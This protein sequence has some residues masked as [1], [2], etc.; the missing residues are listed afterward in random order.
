[1]KRTVAVVP[2]VRSASCALICEIASFSARSAALASS[3]RASSMASAATRSTSSSIAAARSVRMRYSESACTGSS[4]RSL[5]I[6]SKA[7]VTVGITSAAR[8]WRSEA[9]RTCSESISRAA[10]SADWRATRAAARSLFACR[11]ASSATIA[12]APAAAASSS[13]FTSSSSPSIMPVKLWGADRARLEARSR[14]NS[15]PLASMGYFFTARSTT[16]NLTTGSVTTGNCFLFS[17][18]P[19]SLALPISASAAA[20]AAATASSS[21]LIHTTYSSYSSGWLS[22]NF[23]ACCPSSV[24]CSA[25]TAVGATSGSRHLRPS[26]CSAVSSTSSSSDSPGVISDA[27]SD[28]QSS[29]FPL[30]AFGLRSGLGGMCVN[31]LL[32]PSAAPGSPPAMTYPTRLTI[33]SPSAALSSSTL[34]SSP[35]PLNVAAGSSPSCASTP[36]FLRRSSGNLCIQ[37]ERSV[38]G[39]SSGRE[40][41]AAVA[42]AS[43]SAKDSGGPRITTRSGV[44]L[45]ASRNWATIAGIPPTRG[46]ELCEASASAALS[47]WSAAAAAPAPKPPW[48]VGRAS[49][50]TS[51]VAA[52]RASSSKFSIPGS[53]IAATATADAGICTKPTPNAAAMAAATSICVGAAHL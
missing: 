17:P 48:W 52:T 50:A 7:S 1:M 30:F 36:S 49:A 23:S 22:L 2:I 40:Y 51:S 4:G 10:S 20:A 27:I 25:S 5:S 14:E 6:W 18:P 32:Q 8:Y 16:R 39:V 24:I 19:P 46:G 9:E 28:P 44:R 3:T 45:F 47:S 12:A 38:A 15:D 33:S 42:A 31:T 41:A 29:S 11:N 53:A 21:A 37:S 43:S 35:K 26:D 34:T 13:T